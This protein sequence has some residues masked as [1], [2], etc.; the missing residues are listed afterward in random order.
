VLDKLAHG[1]SAEEIHHQYP[2]LTLSQIYA[3]LAY[4]HDHQSELDAEIDHR[5]EEVSRR[6]AEQADSPFRERLRKLGIRP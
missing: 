1:S 3:A 4:Y 2:H 5:L 6:A